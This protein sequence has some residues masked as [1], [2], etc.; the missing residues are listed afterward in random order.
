M[1]VNKDVH[2][3]VGVCVDDLAFALKQPKEFVKAL[4]EKHSFLLKGTGS[5]TH[6]LGADFE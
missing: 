1:C 2:E 5:L 4:E 6:H 3:H